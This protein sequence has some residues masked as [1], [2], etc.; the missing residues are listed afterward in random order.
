MLT[1]TKNMKLHQSPL[2]VLGAL[3]LLAQ[4]LQAAMFAPDSASVLQGSAFSV[5]VRV[6][7]F[8]DITTFQ[9]TLSWTSGVL[10]Y[11]SVSD[12]GLP[13]MSSGNFGF[14]T[15][16]PGVL[17]V[18]WDDS[19]LAGVSRTDGSIA[20]SINFVATGTS[21]LHTTLDFGDNP[22]S[23]EVTANIG[24]EPVE[25]NF[26]SAPGTFVVTPV[27]EPINLALGLF[28]GVLIGAT[29]IRQIST[30]GSRLRLLQSC[31]R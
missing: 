17:T 6:S 12:F 24:G 30:K 31:L 1:P 16:A 29:V 9:F 11:S 28:A 4:P 8:T 18:S 26:D 15:S 20:F 2:F 10:Q 21:G 3:L 19:T 23:R 13:D 14:R 5:P 7:S 25:V 27:P 22:T